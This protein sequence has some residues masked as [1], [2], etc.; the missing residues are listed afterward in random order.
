MIKYK[1]SR[2]V[3]AAVAAAALALPA[4]ALGHGSVYK[5]I[6]RTSSNPPPATEAGLTTVTRYVVTNHGYSYVIT[7]SNGK[8]T[9][10]MVDFKRMPSAYRNQAGFTKDRLFNEGTV[11]AQPHATCEVASLDY[12][13]ATGLA[14]VLAWQESDPFYSY[15]PF[16]KDSAGLEDDPA[17]WIPVVQQAT[18]VDLNTVSDPAAAC[19][20]IGGT[21]RAAD[22]LQGAKTALY[23]GPL[24]DATNPLNAKIAEQAQQIDQMRQAPSQQG[25]DA[26]TEAA[27]RSQIAQLQRRLQVAVGDELDTSVSGPGGAKVILNA[28]ISKAKAKALKLKSTK[29]ASKS[30][31]LAANGKSDAVLKLTGKASRALNKTKGKTKVTVTAASGDRYAKA[32]GKVSR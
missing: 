27:L 25:S 4:S 8:A 10:G 13:N 9:G 2:I 28:Y 21:Y 29:V 16:Q 24:V 7:E 14:N 12:T 22:T 5:D 32:S 1:H 20:G 26:A 17:D 3:A 15:V 19:A 18:G 11:G 31:T 30:V 6:A 23:S